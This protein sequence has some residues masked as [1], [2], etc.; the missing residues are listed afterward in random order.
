MLLSAMLIVGA[1]Q[2]LESVEAQFDFAKSQKRMCIGLAGVEKV[3]QKKKAAQAYGEVKKYWPQGHPY[4]EEAC[5]RQAELLRSL[6]EVGAAR[7]CFEDVLEVAPPSSDFYIRALLELGHLCRRV[8]QNKQSLEYYQ[9]AADHKK[10]SLKYQILGQAW[11]AKLYYQLQDYALAISAAKEW[12]ARSLSSVD[13]IRATDLLICAMSRNRNW[14]EADSLLGN[15]R[16]KM[17]RRATAPSEEGEAISRALDSLKG[18]K[19]IKLAR[20]GGR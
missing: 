17:A 2:Q 14:R 10:G 18:P 19:E 5:F 12:Q 6:E 3:E 4:V 9:R 15:L 1:F 20:E 7:G 16:K 13:Y 11:L 8:K